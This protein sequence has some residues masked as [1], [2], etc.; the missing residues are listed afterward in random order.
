MRE[1]W[2]PYKN[3]LENTPSFHIQTD[4]LFMVV[5]P[6]EFEIDRNW[7]VAVYAG[8]IT[9]LHSLPF[10]LKMFRNPARWP[11]SALIHDFLYS[12]PILLGTRKCFVKVINRKQCDEIYRNILILEG[13]PRWIAFGRWFALRLAGWLYYKG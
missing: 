2:T 5:E 3:K 1:L 13:C 9:N 12:K 4:G 11:I 10:F 8:F 7:M 6:Y